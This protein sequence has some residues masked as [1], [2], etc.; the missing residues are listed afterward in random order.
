LEL[1]A[2]YKPG[3]AL[4]TNV[5]FYTALLL[6]TLGFP[7][8]AFTCVFAAS[9]AGGWIAHARE[10]AQRGRLIRPQSRY[11]GPRPAAAA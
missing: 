7:R 4:Q 11:V 9:R 8:E 1:L 5:E 2:Q 3:R 10:Q 6:E